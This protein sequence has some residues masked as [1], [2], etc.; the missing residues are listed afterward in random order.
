MRYTPV[1]DGHG[2]QRADR[3]N[4]ELHRA[5]LARLRERPDLR[6]PC[7][8]LVARWLAAPEQRPSRPWLERWQELLARSGDDEIAATVLDPDGGQT[9]RQCSPLGPV[10]APRERWAILA[11]VDRAERP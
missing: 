10:L 4:L 11:A 2:H 5:A 7:L 3:R 9:L 8:A 6:A 1:M